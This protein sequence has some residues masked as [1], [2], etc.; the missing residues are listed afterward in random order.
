M[1]R[2]SPAVGR[3]IALLNLLA[4]SPDRPLTLTEIAR[5][6]EYLTGLRH[7]KNLMLA[8]PTG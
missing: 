7:V 4:E 5:I 3:A 6:L 1:T 8:W 2:Q